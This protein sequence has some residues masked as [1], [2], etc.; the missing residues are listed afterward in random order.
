MGP[1]WPGP[2]DA[3]EHVVAVRGGDRC[4]LRPFLTRRIF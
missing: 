3:V 4:A 1:V 2:I